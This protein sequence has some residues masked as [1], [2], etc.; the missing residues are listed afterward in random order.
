MADHGAVRVRLLRER[1]SERRSSAVEPGTGAPASELHPQ[2]QDG[3]VQR[4]HRAGR[5]LCTRA[6]I[7]AK[8]SEA[9]HRRQGSDASPRRSFPPR[10]WPGASIARSIWATSTLSPPTR[11]T[12][13]PIRPEP[14][15]SR[16][17]RSRSRSRRSGASPAGTRSSS[18]DACSGCSRSSTARCTC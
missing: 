14:G 8:T 12:T 2:P 6:W 5:S 4:I 16:S 7:C 13:S 17:S 10:R 3:D 11:A 1:E 9:D 15:R 18:S